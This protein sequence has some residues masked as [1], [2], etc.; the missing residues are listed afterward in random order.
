MKNESNYFAKHPVYS[1]LPFHML[2]TQSLIGSL[3]TV[4]LDVIK[5]GLPKI[6][7]EITTRREKCKAKLM[8]LGDDFP[9]KDEEK[10]EMVFN[11][12]RKFK[13]F[14]DV[15]IGGKYSHGTL[16]DSKD[17]RKKMLKIENKISYQIQELFDEF[18]RDFSKPGFNI[19]SDLADRDIRKAIEYYQGDSIPGFPSFDS[20]LYLV[21][22]KLD[23]LEMPIINLI[24]ESY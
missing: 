3:S 19:C 13:D 22:P 12:V 16:L 10:M 5:K 7:N 14:L 17:S 1:S 15:E 20:F 23:K 24:N 9:D 21:H 11:M 8:E 2:G 18:F 4:L 6:R